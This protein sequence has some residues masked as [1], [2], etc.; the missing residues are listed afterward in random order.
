MLLP[1]LR[2]HCLVGKLQECGITLNLRCLQVPELMV[3]GG[4]VSVC[5][6]L[7]HIPPP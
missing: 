4:M 3:Y 5:R 7:Q 1:R 2:Q 6:D